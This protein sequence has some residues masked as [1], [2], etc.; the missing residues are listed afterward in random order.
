MQHFSAVP[1]DIS[2]SGSLQQVLDFLDLLDR[3]DF[4]VRLDLF[5]LSKAAA[6]PGVTPDQLNGRLRCNVLAKKND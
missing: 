2:L 6:G 4:I 1:Y 5:N 3:Q